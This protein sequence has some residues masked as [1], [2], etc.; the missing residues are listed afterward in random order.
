MGFDFAKAA[1]HTEHVAKS[2]SSISSGMTQLLDYC[3]AISPSPAWSSIRRLDFED[4][5]ADLRLWLEKVLSS[6]PPS[7]EVNAFWFGLF[8]PVLD[9]GETSCGLYVSGSTS[10]D[11]EDETAEWAVPTGDSYLPEGRYAHSRV[12]GDAY[13]LVNK[14]GVADIGEYVLCLGYASLAVRT[15]SR[16]LSPKL[17]LGRRKSRAIAVGFDSGDFIILDDI[18]TQRFPL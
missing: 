9:N 17:L 18:S 6:E 7:Q 5:S 15:I 13:R 4:D 14:N 12:L 16:S 8:N 3:E 11:P 2:A 10:F 1:E